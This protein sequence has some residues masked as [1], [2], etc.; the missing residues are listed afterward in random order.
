MDM[1][2]AYNCKGFV[3]TQLPMRQWSKH[4]K[5]KTW[6]KPE[7]E[8]GR[9]WLSDGGET[10]YRMGAKLAIG[11]GSISLRFCGYA[12]ASRRWSKHKKTKSYPSVVKNRNMI[13]LSTI[14]PP[15]RS[16]TNAAIYGPYFDIA[17]LYCPISDEHSIC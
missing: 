15:A 13:S 12:I 14:H 9:N 11:R 10:G 17:S 5:H 7:P 6:A 16:A 1:Y 4:K 8:W 3:V 2:F